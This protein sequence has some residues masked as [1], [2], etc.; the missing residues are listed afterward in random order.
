M[1]KETT[2]K[3]KAANDGNAILA[4]C[5]FQTSGNSCSVDAKE[6]GKVTIIWNKWE[7]KGLLIADGHDGKRMYIKPSA[8][9]S[10]EIYF[11]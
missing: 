1:E 6:F 4:E 9:N 7:D 11:R 10:F 5:K 8:S 3:Q 2:T